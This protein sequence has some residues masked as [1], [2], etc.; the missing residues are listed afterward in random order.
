MIVMPAMLLM[1]IACMAWAWHYAF[2]GKKFIDI[3][4]PIVEESK[5]VSGADGNKG[6]LAEHP[7]TYDDEKQQPFVAVEK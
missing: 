5:D 7:Q 6:N 1:V 4:C 2:G 3:L